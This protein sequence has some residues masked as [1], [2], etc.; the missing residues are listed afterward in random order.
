MNKTGFVRQH[1]ILRKIKGSV[2]I[3]KGNPKKKYTGEFKQQ[4]V[5]TMREENLSF[6]ETAKRFQIPNPA[7]VSRW[8]KIYLEEGIEGLYTARQHQ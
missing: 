4:V 7:S 1:D 3:P 6:Q 2:V 5:E 8:E